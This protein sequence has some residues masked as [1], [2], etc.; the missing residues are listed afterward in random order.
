MALSYR[1]PRQS[2]PL[3]F[4]CRPI[5]RSSHFGFRTQ[6][7]HRE[8]SVIRYGIHTRVLGIPVTDSRRPLASPGTPQQTTAPSPPQR[9]WPENKP[10][11]PAG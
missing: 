9:A 1:A 6:T 8:E 10:L 3:A 11:R 5:P 2:D 4:S 7:H